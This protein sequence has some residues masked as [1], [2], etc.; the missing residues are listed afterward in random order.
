MAGSNQ[1]G[2]P[3]RRRSASPDALPALC[4]VVDHLP[5]GVFLL[6]SDARILFHNRCSRELLETSGAF[7]IRRGRL[8]IGDERATDL[9]TIEKHP[10]STVRMGIASLTAGRKP[11]Q[12]A[13]AEHRIHVTRLTLRR[14]S[15][16]VAFIVFATTAAR[17]IS[18]PV[19]K[20]LYR[21]TQAEAATA[22]HLFA[23]NRPAQIAA[24]L[25]VSTNTVRSHMK[26][27]FAKCAVNSQ[28]ELVRLFA[29]GPGVL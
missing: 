25:K 21:L 28:I 23:G 14:K 6:E 8:F 26:R 17:Q 18:T 3:E 15:D 4:A 1:P 11:R 10:G 7:S 19:L 29:L 16:P 5:V 9:A 20:Q 2:N 13:T 24:Q 22:A 27:I 12:T